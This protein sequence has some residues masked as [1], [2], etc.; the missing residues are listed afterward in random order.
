M[1]RTLTTRRNIEHPV[2]TLI[3][4]EPSFGDSG[5]KHFTEHELEQQGFLFLTEDKERRFAPTTEATTTTPVAAPAPHTGATDF[6]VKA[7]NA[8]SKTRYESSDGQRSRVLIGVGPKA[9]YRRACAHPGCNKRARSGAT[10]V[11]KSYCAKHGGGRVC[12]HPQCSNVVPWAG[13][14]VCR[15]HGAGVRCAIKSNHPHELPFGS[16]QLGPNPMQRI[17]VSGTLVPRPQYANAFCCAKCF[18][19][20]V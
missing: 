16:K 8:L 15:R 18:K 19:T 12:S 2:G 1:V 3:G 13:Y 11:Q 17:A 6:T 14:T 10:Q 9:R 20:F 4:A 5:A 7:C